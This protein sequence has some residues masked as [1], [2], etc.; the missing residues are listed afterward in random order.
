MSFKH[1]RDIVTAWHDNEGS[2]SGSGSPDPSTSVDAEA[3]NQ[4]HSDR[5]GG[6]WLRKNT[7]PQIEGT[8][9]LSDDDR[10]SSRERLLSG[11]LQ[12]TSPGTKRDQQRHHHHHHHHH[13]HGQQQQLQ[14][15]QAAPAPG[16]SGRARVVNGLRQD[17]LLPSPLIAA[18]KHDSCDASYPPIITIDGRVDT[19]LDHLLD[20]DNDDDQ[21]YDGP[22]EE[23]PS[24]YPKPH[25]FSVIHGS[26]DDDVD[27][28]ANDDGT[29]EHTLVDA[30]KNFHPKDLKDVAS[31]D[32]S[33]SRAKPGQIKGGQNGSRT[34]GG[35]SQLLHYTD[36]SHNKMH[37]EGSE[38]ER[39]DIYSAGDQQYH[40]QP[41]SNQRQ[42]GKMEKTK[43]PP[44]PLSRTNTGM[45][46][47]G[48][49]RQVF[50]DDGIPYSQSE[51]VNPATV[52]SDSFTA[53]QH[54][55]GP[56]EV[57]RDAQG[58]QILSKP[59]KFD[60]PP[61]PDST[62]GMP[63][64]LLENDFQ[65]PLGSKKEVKNYTEEARSNSKHSIQPNPGKSMSGQTKPSGDCEIIAVRRPASYTSKCAARR[66]KRCL[67]YPRRSATRT[68]TNN[69]D[70]D[71]LQSGEDED[72]D[73]TFITCRETLNKSSATSAAIDSRHHA[74]KSSL[75]ERN[76]QELVPCARKNSRHRSSKIKTGEDL[77]S[78]V[79]SVKG[80]DSIQ[81]DSD[82]M[83]DPSVSE[84]VGSSDKYCS[85]PLATKKKF[86]ISDAEMSKSD[87]KVSVDYVPKRCLRQRRRPQP[88]NKKQTQQFRE[89]P[90]DAVELYEDASQSRRQ[91]KIKSPYFEH[92]IAQNQ[93]HCV[94]GKDR[95]IAKSTQ[96]FS[97]HQG[98]KYFAISK[99]STEKGYRSKFLIKEMNSQENGPLKECTDSPVVERCE[100]K[101]NQN[102]ILAPH[103][104]N[105]IF[106]D[107]EQC[108]PIHRLQNR[109]YRSSP[110]EDNKGFHNTR[111]EN[112][113]TPRTFEEYEMRDTRETRRSGDDSR[114]RTSGSRSPIK[115]DVQGHLSSKEQQRQ[116]DMLQK[117]AERLAAFARATS[118]IMINDEVSLSSPKTWNGI[119]QF[120][121]HKMSESPERESSTQKCRG[122]N[123]PIRSKE[124]R[125]TRHISPRASWSYESDHSPVVYRYTSRM[126]P[127]QKQKM[128][129]SQSEAVARTEGS[130]VD[131]AYPF[132]N[133][134]R[135]AD[136]KM[137]FGDI[138]TKALVNNST[139]EDLKNSLKQAM[140]IARK[141]LNAAAKV[142]K[143][144]NLV[145]SRSR[146]SLDSCSFAGSYKDTFSPE[147]FYPDSTPVKHS[148]RWA[149]RSPYASSR[150]TDLSCL[151]ARLPRS[152]PALPHTSHI[153][154][155]PELAT[156]CEEPCFIGRSRAAHVHPETRRSRSMVSDRTNIL[157]IVPNYRAHPD[158]SDGYETPGP[159]VSIYIGGSNTH[160]EPQQVAHIVSGQGHHDYPQIDGA[161]D[162]SACVST[163]SLRTYKKKF[164]ESPTEH[165]N[166]VCFLEERQGFS[167][168]RGNSKLS[169]NPKKTQIVC[170]NVITTQPENIVTTSKHSDSSNSQLFES[171]KETLENNKSVSQTDNVADKKFEEMKQN[172]GECRQDQDVP[173]H[174]D[175]SV[176]PTLQRP[177]RQLQS[178]ETLGKTCAK[179]YGKPYR[180]FPESP[181]PSAQA[182]TSFT[183]LSDMLSTRFQ[184]PTS[185]DSRSAVMSAAIR[186]L[187]K[188]PQSFSPILPRS[189]VA[190]SSPQEKATLRPKKSSPS[191]S[192]Y[193]SASEGAMTQTK[194][195][196]PAGKESSCL[197]SPGS[198]VDPS[199]YLT[200][201][202]AVDPPGLSSKSNF[203]FNRSP[204]LPLRF[205]AQGNNKCF[206]T[207]DMPVLQKKRSPNY[208]EARHLITVD[209]KATSQVSQRNKTDKK[210][211]SINQKYCRNFGHRSNTL[212]NSKA[213]ESNA[214]NL[215]CID[216]RKSKSRKRKYAK[217]RNQEE[218]AIDKT[219]CTSQKPISQNDVNNNSSQHGNH[220]DCE[221]PRAVEEE[222]D[223]NFVDAVGPEEAFV[224]GKE[225]E[226]KA[227]TGMKASNR[228]QNQP[229]YD[230]LRRWPADEARSED[231]LRNLRASKAE[232]DAP[233]GILVSKNK[234]RYHRHPSSHKV[235]KSLCIA[236]QLA[237]ESLSAAA[238]V[239]RLLN[240]VV[241]VYQHRYPYDTEDIARLAVQ[242]HAMI[243]EILA[244]TKDCARQRTDTDTKTFT[245]D[246]HPRWRKHSL[247][248]LD[249]PGDF[250]DTLKCPRHR[251][252]RD[253]SESGQ[254]EKVSRSPSPRS[255]REI[256]PLFPQ[257][258]HCRSL[259]RPKGH[260]RGDRREHNR[261]SSPQNKRTKHW[262]NENPDELELIGKRKR[263]VEFCQ[264]PNGSGECFAMKRESYPGRKD[265]EE[266]KYLE[267]RHSEEPGGKDLIYRDAHPDPIKKHR[268]NRHREKHHEGRNPEGSRKQRRE[269]G[270]YS[271]ID[272]DDLYRDSPKRV[273]SH[274]KILRETKSSRECGQSPGQEREY[275]L[276]NGQ[277]RK[278]HRKN[279]HA[280]P[281]SIS[282]KDKKNKK[283][284]DADERSHRSR[285]EKGHHGNNRD[286]QIRAVSPRKG[287][288]YRENIRKV[289]S[290]VDSPEHLKVRQRA[291]E[292]ALERSAQKSRHNSRQNT[293]EETSRRDTEKIK[294]KRAS[295]SSKSNIE[296]AEDI[297][298]NMV[299]S[300]AGSGEIGSLERE[301]KKSARSQSA[302]TR[303]EK[304]HKRKKRPKS[305]AGEKKFSKSHEH[306]KSRSSSVDDPSL[307]RE[308]DTAA[309]SVSVP[310]ATDGKNYS[311]NRS[312]DVKSHSDN[313]LCIPVKHRYP[314]MSDKAKALLVNCEPD[315]SEQIC[316][317]REQFLKLGCWVNTRTDVEDKE[318]L[319]SD[320]CNKL[321]SEG[322]EPSDTKKYQDLKQNPTPT[323]SNQEIK[324]SSSNVFQKNSRSENI[325]A[326]KLDGTSNV[327]SAIFS[328]EIYT[329]Q[330]LLVTNR[331][332]EKDCITPPSKLNEGCSSCP[333]SPTANG[334]SSSSGTLTTKVQNRA[335][336]MH[337]HDSGSAYLKQ[338][339]NT[340][341]MNDTTIH[342]TFTPNVLQ[343][344]C[345]R[346]HGDPSCHT[347]DAVYENGNL[348]DCTSFYNTCSNTTT[349]HNSEETGFH[350][351]VN[352]PSN[353][354]KKEEFQ[355]VTQSCRNRRVRSNNINTA[356]SKS[357]THDNNEVSSP[358]KTRAQPSEDGP[359]CP[360]S[361][362]GIA[363][364]QGTGSLSFGETYTEGQERHADEQKDRLFHFAESPME[365]VEK[366]AHRGQQ[367]PTFP[368]H[369]VSPAAEGDISSSY[370][371]G[372]PTNRRP[373]S[374]GPMREMPE[375]SSGDSMRSYT[376]SSNLTYGE[377]E[378]YALSSSDQSPKVLQRHKR[379]YYKKQPRAFYALKPIEKLYNIPSPKLCEPQL[380]VS[381]NQP[382]YRY[383]QE[384]GGVAQPNTSRGFFMQNDPNC[385][386]ELKPNA[387]P[388]FRGD[389][390]N[391]ESGAETTSPE[392]AD[393]HI[394][395]VSPHNDPPEST[396][397][398]GGVCGR[399]LY[400]LYRPLDN[401]RLGSFSPI[402]E[403][404]EITAAASFRKPECVG[405]PMDAPRS[406][407]RW[408]RGSDVTNNCN[409]GVVAVT[410]A[411]PESGE[412]V[413]G[414]SSNH[415]GEDDI[416]LLNSN[417]NASNN[418]TLNDGGLDAEEG[419]RK[420]DSDSLGIVPRRRRCRSQPV[421][422]E[423]FC[424]SKRRPLPPLKP[425]K[426]MKLQ[427]PFGFLSDHE[428]LRLYNANKT[429][430]KRLIE[431][432]KRGC[433]FDI[434]NSPNQQS[435]SRKRSTSSS[436]VSRISVMEAIARENEQ[437]LRRIINKES[438]YKREEQLRD[439]DKM[440][441]KF[442]S[443]AKYPETFIKNHNLQFE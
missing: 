177:D 368:L 386:M 405:S 397:E 89:L 69:G 222:E 443:F 68:L 88:S 149:Q 338:K 299:S 134:K 408:A 390:S 427:G 276:E 111:R 377:D 112:T 341:T 419:P 392:P 269:A 147:F 114:K 70:D 344:V 290:S 186:Y 33:S 207:A 389:P 437:L 324:S 131:G 288:K 23:I 191:N 325:I 19:D 302:E 37:P 349:S 420:S 46:K 152:R 284:K 365:G 312:L 352:G 228:N 356:F 165:K 367:L 272:R 161:R 64:V 16:R 329:H 32:T 138:S 128:D 379:T 432:K 20:D 55:A 393:G 385:E 219:A 115:L 238:K 380:E 143:A 328:K 227:V 387:P 86:S 305:S 100:D 318:D 221:Y 296:T 188:Y 361:E 381:R 232:G 236:M 79:S 439:Y 252:R 336:S 244:S 137:G 92:N 71:N 39:T 364:G 239:S 394:E 30:P 82:D 374:F 350:Y 373:H 44:R 353:S 127:Y 90:R 258:Y 7:D 375:Y 196:D 351:V 260:S 27:S 6:R 274:H 13:H 173:T 199:G 65:S 9:L 197:W 157:N 430:C 122:G 3:D 24:K 433:T 270:F 384:V 214:V 266:L 242:N 124:S 354:N 315:E 295:R 218:R 94:D 403:E 409:A 421:V 257:V 17:L 58:N 208:K 337:H 174:E 416:L 153:T 133:N 179:R 382:H 283:L 321:R 279:R 363:C 371:N 372:G 383:L 150:N 285:L 4:Q 264:S 425:S 180:V 240:Q 142:S 348:N 291:E 358:A 38:A 434:G 66:D 307:F 97:P 265:R 262:V 77:D 398:T 36:R 340:L 310:A 22:V 261:S 435:S 255:Y 8:A 42:Q 424:Q 293:C 110:V 118:P 195:Q 144:L 378:D 140:E 141:S 226:T 215:E 21:H 193:S 211:K 297:S 93:V 61:E 213:V 300:H 346:R 246:E 158:K 422:P 162:N 136:Y 225:T 342:K 254:R 413:S 67:D 241:D 176:R 202:S 323:S 281:T 190:S 108:R 314:A 360:N 247:R 135:V 205:L 151:S 234:D 273:L 183:K 132:R 339:E 74:I 121:R 278:E 169:F 332:T 105:T 334:L 220:K 277:E 200:G 166:D 249:F 104:G 301:R 129:K 406:R 355:S 369:V 116:I 271:D 159:L 52:Y 250:V 209:D 322:P 335:K 306:R 160:N 172:P 245:Y 87:T 15:P 40:D 396:S 206:P 106:H 198:C 415:P 402:I 51:Q 203:N 96:E 156:S 53:V 28:Y 26:L 84:D 182:A 18:G 5:R 78:E 263:S 54:R 442:L 388:L 229:D 109:L 308:N 259:E 12:P 212:D 395:H 83:Y 187:R 139:D 217:H 231:V 29:L 170:A 331:T 117:R 41:E 210:N 98:Q 436:A 163:A 204:P 60:G 280:G 56:P 224:L 62:N 235:R 333:D 410:F 85:D 429:L 91:G 146:L 81:S 316:T 10:E 59:R 230:V 376:A 401:I 25:V 327:K 320:Q 31:R 189:K 223:I 171:T 113:N 63:Q 304:K 11:R 192:V 72:E 357:V 99:V 366:R 251:R 268:V 155:S 130:S 145:I 313:H 233:I 370:E 287:N 184:S 417:N 418:H 95:P 400:S 303:S 194:D 326:Q 168:F 216:S 253:F 289:G 243:G 181:L 345:P 178:A 103:P 47:A 34:R 101:Q 438:F 76:G 57:V 237:D 330:G 309:A 43:M 148:L 107:T 125:I 164:C 440:L 120:W 73:F 75:R 126:I 294:T 2:F 412:A 154:A 411:P 404:S 359:P 123:C 256:D 35:A 428:K 14:Q 311:Y 407:N 50:S 49:R 80:F 167:E 286:D 391:E 317:K 399:G 119:E 275:Y 414:R 45:A 185:P 441:P 48:S 1:K 431:V 347:K 292:E 426:T 175:G 298:D 267:R 319:K 102:R 248:D 201:G 282:G 362:N 343:R 423:P